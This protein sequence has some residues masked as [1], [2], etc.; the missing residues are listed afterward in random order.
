MPERLS[1]PPSRELG[2]VRRMS[3]EEKYSIAETARRKSGSEASRRD[4]RLAVGHSHMLDMLLKDIAQ[5]EYEH[6]LKT[7]PASPPVKHSDMHITWANK[8]TTQQEDEPQFEHIEEYDDGAE[9]L[10]SL[11]LCRTTTHGR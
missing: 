11:S 2:L 6:A 4:L 1:R 8:P 9:D 10:D 5:E 7:P 3:I